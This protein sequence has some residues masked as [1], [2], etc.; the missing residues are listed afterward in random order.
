[1]VYD[2]HNWISHEVIHTDDMNHLETGIVDAFT[3]LTEIQSTIEET[4]YINR[5]FTYNDIAIAAGVDF[6]I[7]DID[8]HSGSAIS[9][10]VVNKGASTDVRVDVYAALGTS[11][12][13][14]NYI[15]TMDLS[16][17]VTSDIIAL[18]PP[19]DKIKII[20]TNEDLVNATTVD[21]VVRVVG[22]SAFM[23][24][25]I[26]DA[27]FDGIVNNADFA[28]VADRLNSG[29]NG[30]TYVEIAAEI[31]AD[32]EAHRLVATAHH[33]NVNDPTVDQKAALAG[34]N[35]T[36]SN[37]N[38]YVTN[39]D[40]RL[41]NSRTPLAHTHT[42]TN[43]TDLAANYEPLIASK[44]TAF[45]KDFG[46]VAGTVCEGSDARLSNDR[47]PTI[48]A[49]IHA[50]D[51]AD[52]IKL[53][54]LA[55]PDDNTDLNV[56]TLK[57]GL[58]PKLEGNDVHYLRADGTWATPPGAGTGGVV[59]G[60]TAGT[61]CEGN[62]VRL[63]DARDPSLHANS[64][65]VT[66]ADSIHIDELAASSDNTNLNS[67]VAAHGLLPKL[68][69]V[70]SVKFL[71]GDGTW[72][73]PDG[74]VPAV[75][76]TS[77]KAGGSDAIK[78]DELAAGTDVT[79]LNTSVTAHGL[80][81]KLNGTATTFLNGTGS[82]T[83][84]A[85][86]WA[87]N[88]GT[89]AGKICQGND[90]RLSDNRTPTLHAVSHKVG[91]PDAIKL[92]E[93]AVP[94]DTS[95][96]ILDASTTVHG[97]LPKLAGGTAKFLRADGTWEI[98]PGTLVLGTTAGTACAGD[99]SRLTDNR[100]PVLHATSHKSGGSDAIKLDELAAPTDVATLNASSTAHGLLPKLSGSVNTVLRGD[101]T[102]G[103]YSSSASNFI[104]W[105]EG[106]LSTSTFFM[107]YRV[108]SNRVI[109]S[110]KGYMITK[111]AGTNLLVDVR[112]NSNTSVGSV[113]TSDAA[114]AITTGATLTNGLYQFD[115]SGAL[116]SGMTSMIDG[117]IIFIAITQVGST[118]AG[119]GLYVEVGF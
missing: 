71:K 61:V 52:P 54:D 18:A 85:G 72:A 50:A 40:S 21:V 60:T 108:T 39:T 38:R 1:M 87:S 118:I 3:E 115:F 13:T 84:P 23:I 58:C 45:N 119:A 76:A 96:T 68:D 10:E 34:T 41:T 36:P 14:T 86:T 82:W 22:S 29:V 27:D 114:Q 75:H 53:D 64:H 44:G 65:T 6:E 28:T 95:S 63:S 107:P 111:P 99:D 69:G 112:K 19:Q 20:I 11:E 109:R 93:F 57:H 31:D 48:H 91:G 15:S 80:C 83:V 116:D 49:S 46:A 43:I 17:I 7:A 74:G 90:S 78:L 81:P 101:G 5:V 97:L 9:V 55:Q 12:Y 73:S 26:Y 47:A 8:T 33:S 51:G 105:E 92:D 66:G 2:K 98:P 94:T 77:H 88:F 67:S 110:I 62:D 113:F 89:T 100:T 103:E 42:V 102:W 24:Q 79:T 25:T 35:G 4:D 16:A 59:F 37:A 117:D 56:S 32:I 104:R 106:A 70:A 30:K